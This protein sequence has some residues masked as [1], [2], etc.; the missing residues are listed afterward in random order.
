M[1]LPIL[2]SIGVLVAG[3]MAAGLVFLIKSLL[4]P[5][6]I[7]QLRELIKTGKAAQAVKIAKGMLSK[8]PRNFEAHYYLGL[9]YLA[10]NKPELAFMEMKTVNQISLFSRDVP[11]VEFRKKMAELFR[12]FEQDE[13]ALKEYILLTTLD[14]TDAE[15][16]YNSGLIFEERGKPDQAVKFYKKTLELDPRH[17]NTHIHLGLLLFR[18]KRVGEAKQELE[19]ALKLNP[20]NYQANY[21]LG[22]ILKDNQDF[23][24][25]LI[26]FERAQKD[27]DLKLK[28]LVERGSCFLSQKNYDRAQ[29]ELERALKLS[30]NDGDNETLFARYF[31]ALCYEKNRQI[32]KAVG[33]WEKIYAKKPTFKDVA[34]KLSAYQDLRVDDHMKDYITSSKPEFLE[35]CSKITNSM[36]FNVRD[37]KEIP[38]GV[39][40]VSMEN[41]SDKWRNV[42][43]MPKLMIFL[44]ISNQVEEGTVRALA[45]AAKKINA[46]RAIC[47][48]NTTFHRSAIAYAETRP[49]DL[50][51][52]D[53]LQE[54]LNKI[55]L[56]G[57]NSRR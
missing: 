56:S 39:E 32:D 53:Q 24:G 19:I 45:E 3:A 7:S 26:A 15:N 35:I 14:P 47:I 22:K 17:S 41:E 13:E 25:A 21:Y 44:R 36:G 27:P 40:I 9:A 6:R 28:A 16:F 8:E 31:L 23:N 51:G 49:M 12:R 33:E 2:I 57:D 11:E 52:K 37:S 46:A 55:D 48:T 5:K 43:K 30:T 34:E 38:N 29:V 10:E 4:L 1:P 20:E 42:K 50:I 18:A 54:L